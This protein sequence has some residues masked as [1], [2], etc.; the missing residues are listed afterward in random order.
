MAFLIKIE[1]PIS[2]N[3]YRSI[4]LVVQ[5]YKNSEPRYTIYLISKVAL[6]FPIN[7]FHKTYYK[8]LANIYYDKC[9]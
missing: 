8:E 4:K 9:F 5:G 2:G 7:T 6:S 1:K 3:V